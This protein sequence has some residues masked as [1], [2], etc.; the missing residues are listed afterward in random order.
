MSCPPKVDSSYAM[1]QYLLA[2]VVKGLLLILLRTTGI[3][4]FWQQS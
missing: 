1:S 2:E 4:K 3:A